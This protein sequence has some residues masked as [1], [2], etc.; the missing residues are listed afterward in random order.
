M[1]YVQNFFLRKGKRS[2]ILFIVLSIERSNNTPS[3]SP[4][5]PGGPSPKCDEQ[6]PKQWVFAGCS[7]T[8]QSTK[9][10]REYVKHIRVIKVLGLKKSQ[11][12]PGWIDRCKHWAPLY[13]LLLLCSLLHT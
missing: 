10:K 11:T 13:P 5:S 3:S 4:R 6:E 9:R 1:K 12:S 2:G 7:N 8:G